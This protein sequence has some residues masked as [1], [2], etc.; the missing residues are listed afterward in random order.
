MTNEIKQVSP[1]GIVLIADN[2]IDDKTAKQLTDM[3]NYMLQNQAEEDCEQ[4]KEETTSE[5]NRLYI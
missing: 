2:P 3:I 5:Y 1:S 4:E